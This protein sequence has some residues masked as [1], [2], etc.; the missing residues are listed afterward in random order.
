MAK[1]NPNQPAP[2]VHV[3]QPGKTIQ[4]AVANARRT[5]MR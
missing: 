1:G 2:Q 4:Q 5:S 3:H